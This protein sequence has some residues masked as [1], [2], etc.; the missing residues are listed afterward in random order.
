ML[1]FRQNARA[2]IDR[3]RGGESIV[4]TYRGQPAVRLEPVKLEP[5][6][7]DPF[8][9]LYELADSKGRSLSNRQIDRIVYGP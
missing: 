7:D 5:S 3:V 2:I 8:Y 1:E 4:L 9:T 6:S